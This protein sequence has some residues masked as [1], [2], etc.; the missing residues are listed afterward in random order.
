MNQRKLTYEYL[1]FGISSI[2][3]FMIVWLALPLGFYSIILGRRWFRLGKYS[4]L[5]FLLVL[6]GFIGIFTSIFLNQLLFYDQIHDGRI[7]LVR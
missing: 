4:L 2:L 6:L 5:D 3:F 7:F 1:I